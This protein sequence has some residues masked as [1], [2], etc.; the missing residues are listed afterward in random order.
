[1]CSY[2]PRQT[3]QTPQCTTKASTHPAPSVGCE[4]F[5][6][7]HPPANPLFRRSL[8]ARSCQKAAKN[9]P[10]NRCWTTIAERMAERRAEL[11]FI[12]DQVVC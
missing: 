8:T 1:M 12:G 2:Q 4:N 9:I 3:A 7:P 6:A 11:P 5:H 10:K